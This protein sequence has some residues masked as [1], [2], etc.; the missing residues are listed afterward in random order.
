[1]RR[2]LIVVV[3]CCLGT[4]IQQVACADTINPFTSDGSL[5]AFDPT[6]DVIFH[7]NDGT[8]SM[9]GKLF[10]GGVL[11]TAGQNDAFLAGI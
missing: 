1:M 6:S 3:F 5:G 10:S 2:V 9:G 7:T 11:V 4:H 8:W